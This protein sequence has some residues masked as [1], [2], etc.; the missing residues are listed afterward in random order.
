MDPFGH[1]A[2]WLYKDII[3]KEDRTSNVWG[4]GSVL[5]PLVDIRPTIAVTRAHMKVV[6]PGEV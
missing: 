1:L 5:I 2:P 4:Y 3:A 6:T